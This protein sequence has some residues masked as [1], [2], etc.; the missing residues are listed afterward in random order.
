MKLY[1]YYVVVLQLTLFIW[2]MKFFFVYIP[3]FFS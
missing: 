1:I 3:V 2:N